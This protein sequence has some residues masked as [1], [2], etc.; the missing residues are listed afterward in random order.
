MPRPSSIERLA[1][2][3]ARLVA[4]ARGIRLLDAISW[5]ARVQQD[6]LA[7]WRRGEARLPAVAYPEQDF[8]DVRREL[9]AVATAAD[10]A[11]P[12]GAYLRSTAESWRVATCLLEALGTPAVTAHAVQL[13]GRPG[14]LLP[15]GDESNLDAAR[16]FL[17][18]ADELDGA[19]PVDE[20]EYCIPAAELRDEMQAALDRFFVGH[21]IRV[22]LDPDLIAKAAA[23]P[24]RVR[25]RSGAAFTEYDRRQLLEHEAF[26]HSLTAINGG[27]Q[28]WIRSLARAAPRATATQEGLAVFAEQISGAIDIN[29]F[30]RISLRVL[31][32]EM[33]LGGA[34]FIEVFRFFLDAGQ[35]E[36]DSFASAQRIFRGAPTTGG[37]AFT[38]DTVYLHGLLSVHTFFRWALH[39]RRL[40]ETRLI[41][42]GK[43]ALQDV[44]A[45]A[46][47][48]DDG[49]LAEPLYI[50][51]WAQRA[52]GLAGMLAFSLFANRIRLNQVDA[53]DLMP[54]RR[55]RPPA[56]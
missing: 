52:N 27:R 12:L 43:F 2:L 17:E 31:A 46:P 3:D 55:G 22:E 42:A 15:G 29:R 53:D 21:T 24:T 25:L 37:S 8:A 20:A 48:F 34:D 41:F 10:P 28:P 9:G 23:G 49:S 6:F 19:L 32:I 51:P 39:H 50:P 54:E 33:A 40:R 7:R 30:K 38:K 13:Y 56:A 45:L 35:T 14:D 26:V 18:I 1:A 44:L 36:A 11:H 16:H 5:P 47:M 4:A